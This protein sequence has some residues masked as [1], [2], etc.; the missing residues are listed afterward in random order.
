MFKSA[1]KK[2]IIIPIILLVS[3]LIA[4]QSKS[5]NVLL[6]SGQNNHAWQKTTPAIQNILEKSGRFF[7][8]VT[9]NP[10]NLAPEELNQYDVIMSNWN[11]WPD[12]TGKRWDP[13]L[14]KAF[15]TFVAEGKGVVIIHAG[16]ST[17]QDWPEFQQIAGG[18]WELGSTGH[19][20]IHT[21]K[22]SI[23]NSNHP[24]TKGLKEF[25]IKDELWHRTKFQ[26]GIKV[27]CSAYSSPEKKGTGQNEPV[28]IVTHYGKGRCCNF[29]LGHDATTMQNAAWQTIMVRATEWAATGKATIS[30]PDNWPINKEM[31][32]NDN[33]K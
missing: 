17:L 8:T 4:C 12:V 25:Y 29:V 27:L 22:V 31:A 30:M 32:Q 7:V 13:D 11:T 5:I 3:S 33:V 26:P 24:I 6:L 15:L 9:N 16:S 21:F 20:P 19:G 10:E 2:T 18:T 28:T 23:E 14:E 1:Q